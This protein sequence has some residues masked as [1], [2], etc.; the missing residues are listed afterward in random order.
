LQK[1]GLQVGKKFRKYRH[2]LL[3]EKAHSL[4][5]QRMGKVKSI[6]PH[7]RNVSIPQN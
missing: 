3:K 2:P 7:N 1:R 4:Q 6:T 5:Q